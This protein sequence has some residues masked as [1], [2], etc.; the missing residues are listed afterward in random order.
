MPH[1]GKFDLVISNGRVMDPDSGLDAVRDIGILDGAVRSIQTGGLQGS[2]MIDAGGHVVA[3]GFVDLHSHGQ[4]DENYRIQALDGVTTALELEVGTLDVDAWYAERE[5]QAVINYGVSAGHI[6]ARIE[7]MDDPGDFL[8][9][10][11][12]ARKE[13]SDGEIAAMAAHLRKGLRDGALAVGFGLQYTPGATRWEVLE[14]FRTAAIFNASCHVHMRG[15]GH[16]EPLNSIEGLVEIIAAAAISGAPLHVVHIQSSG[17]RATTRLL[18]IIEE[19][20][21]RGIDV[22]TECYPYAAGLTEISSAIFD[23][24]WQTKLGIAHSELEWVAT[25]ERLTQATFAQYREEGGLVI[26]HMIPQDA[27]DAAVTSPLTAIATDGHMKNGRGHPR[28]S[29]SYSRVLG[30]FVRE[31]GTLTLMDAI[32][33][34]TLMPARRLEDL[35]PALA[36]KGRVAVGADADLVVFDPQTVID[37]STYQDPV[38]P[39]EGIAHVIVGGTSVVADGRLQPGVAPGAA[40]RAPIGSKHS[41][42]S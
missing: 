15:M 22:T 5:G 14:M 25:G 40:V 21:G 41:G 24:G 32:S 33:K 35:A 27:V 26:A 42:T 7:V 4:D 17:M 11:D 38:S 28:T 37:T 2:N 10:S 29:G 36:R 6:P 16:R 13:A 18:Q 39:P 19:A 34:M 9:V 1:S 30:R 12:G 31:A 20:R 3:P 8:P 23:E